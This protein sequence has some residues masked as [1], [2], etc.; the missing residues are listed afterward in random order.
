MRSLRRGVV[1][2]AV[3]AFLG[4]AVPGA[5]VAAPG[6]VT[7]AE[8]VRTE[9]AGPVDPADPTR[10]GPLTAQDVQALALPSY[11]QWVADVTAVT[12]QAAAFLRTRLPDASGAR[13]AIV[14]D[15]DNTALQTSYRPGLTSPATPGVLELAR[16]AEDAGADVFF[17]TARP[18]ILRG[19]TVYNLDRAGYPRDGLYMRGW[20]DFRSDEALKTA[21][22][23]AIEARGYTIVANIGNNVH[24]LVGGSAERTFKLPDYDGQ[25]S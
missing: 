4:T 12:D 11:Q 14:L 1:V 16:I 21:N 20:F 3:A 9:V 7:V 23:R 8:Q 19:Q 10:P 2:V 13:T 17:V 15:I 5:S 18:E 24:D 6:A 25:L 22:R